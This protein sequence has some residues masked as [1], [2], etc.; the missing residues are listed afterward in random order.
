[1]HRA[2]E[3]YLKTI[4]ELT[5][6]QNIDLVK[7]SD[8]SAR[9]N[10]TDQSVNEM[11]KKLEA[12]KLLV[13]YPY[14]GVGLTRKGLEQAVK[15]IRAHRLW[16]V[17]LTEKLG[18]SWQDVHFDAENLEHAASTQVIDKLDAYLGYPK[19][20]QHGNPIPDAKGRIHHQEQKPLT[21][22]EV[23]DRLKINRATDTK[24]LLGFL[25]QKGLIIGDIITI[26]AVDNF[27]DMMVIT[28]GD[29]DIYLSLQ[30]AQ[31]IYAQS[32]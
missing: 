26:K 5:R 19:F 20:C 22:Y 8:I 24:P 29:Q 6:E 16:E 11:I 28:K 12:K 17:F 25:D 7:T 31:L 21:Q 4:Y 27:N 18:F 32:I 30:N 15:M 14:K 2:E 3:D 23:G 9:F 10:I 1:M 13:F